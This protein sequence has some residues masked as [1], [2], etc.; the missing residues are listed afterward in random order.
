ASAGGSAS[1]GSASPAA[2]WSASAS[3]SSSDGSSSVVGGTKPPAFFWISA[4]SS[5]LA[6]L[7]VTVTTTSGWRATRTGCRPSILIGRSISTGARSTVT[8]P[9]VTAAATSR[10]LTGPYRWPVP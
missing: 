10:G 2:V 6:T 3:T 5:D 4:S 9:A 1:V 7:A 8:P